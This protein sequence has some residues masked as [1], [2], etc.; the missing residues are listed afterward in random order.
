MRIQLSDILEL[1]GALLTIGAVITWNL[2]AGLAL[3]GVLAVVVGYLL[4][5]HPAADETNP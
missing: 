1:L 4:P 3:I 2:H 5:D